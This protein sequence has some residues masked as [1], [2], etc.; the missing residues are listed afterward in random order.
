MELSRD[1]TTVIGIAGFSDEKLRVYR[2]TM[3]PFGAPDWD[4][5]PFTNKVNV[6]IAQQCCELPG[7]KFL[8]TTMAPSGKAIAYGTADGVYVAAIPDNCAP[9]GPGTL[10]LP[11]AKSPDWGPADVPTADA[12]AAAPSRRSPLGRARASPSSSSPS[13]RAAHRHAH[14]GRGRQG[15]GEASSPQARTK[16]SVTVG[17]S[18]QG[19]R[20]PSRPSAAS[21]SR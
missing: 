3:S 18:G 1:L 15:H 17:K 9:G 5:T 2:T 19:H 7:A 12:R 11:G 8:S 14:H 13:A 16:K 10:V 6:P 20:R 21:A 4:H